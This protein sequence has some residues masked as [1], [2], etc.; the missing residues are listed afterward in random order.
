MEKGKNM[1]LVFF[2]NSWYIMVIKRL[3]D[4]LT[5]AFGNLTPGGIF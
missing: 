2:I 5:P 4:P 1:F 3:G